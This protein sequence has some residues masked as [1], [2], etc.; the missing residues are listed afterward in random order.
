[1]STTTLTPN[2]I[3]VRDA[4]IRQLESP[5]ISVVRN[6]ITVKPADFDTD[7]TCEIC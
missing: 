6:L 7:D 5:G 2:D 3:V 1:M 4:V